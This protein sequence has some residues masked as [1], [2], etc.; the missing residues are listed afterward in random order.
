ML[1][2]SIIKFNQYLQILIEQLELK[3]Q[4]GCGVSF[5]LKFFITRWWGRKRLVSQYH[6]RQ[7]DKK[8]QFLHVAFY[9]NQIFFVQLYLFCCYGLYCLLGI[10]T[11]I[12]SERKNIKIIKSNRRS[13]LAD[14]LSQNRQFILIN[15]NCVLHF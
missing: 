3:K 5:N 1:Q 4:L 6:H 12:S 7:E 2:Y 11:L 14:E 13:R 9:A 10:S 15:G 8:K